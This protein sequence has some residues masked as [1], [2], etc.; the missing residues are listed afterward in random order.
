MSWNCA[1]TQESQVG[2]QV[3]CQWHFLALPP[4]LPS[5]L[6]VLLVFTF[7]FNS[8]SLP[9]NFTFPTSLQQFS[10][11]PAVL[12]SFVS[13][14]QVLDLSTQVCFSLGSLFSHGPHSPGL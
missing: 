8:R 11:V 2:R 9:P 12:Y 10:N 6:V 3:Q 4:F 14:F 1:H 13:F 5:F 7:I